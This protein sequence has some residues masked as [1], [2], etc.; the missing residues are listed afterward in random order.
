MS[1]LVSSISQVRIERVKKRLS[2]YID[3]QLVKRVKVPRKV[4]VGRELFLGGLPSRVVGAE[5]SGCLF[6]RSKHHLCLCFPPPLTLLHHF[7]RKPRATTISPSPTVH[8]IISLQRHK[9]SPSPPLCGPRRSSHC[10]GVWGTWTSMRRSTRSP[11]RGGG[12][13]LLESASASPASSPAPTSPGMPMLFIVSRSEGVC[14]YD[15]KDDVACGQLVV[16]SKM[17]KHLQEKV[18]KVGERFLQIYLV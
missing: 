4:N 8:N 3:S 10:E 17:Y 18:W 15:G 14:V 6:S 11:A 5:V 13:R 2:L 1:H 12:T 9:L 7:S 16:K